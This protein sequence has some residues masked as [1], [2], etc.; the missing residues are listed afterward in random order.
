MWSER[1]TSQGRAGSA[2]RPLVSVELA[3]GVRAEIP[4]FFYAAETAVAKM[5]LFFRKVALI[6]FFDHTG[7]VRHDSFDPMNRN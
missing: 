4:R 7:R 2:L 1:L 6:G 5:L 3:R